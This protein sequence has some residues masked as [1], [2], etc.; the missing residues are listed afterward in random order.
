[1]ITPDVNLLLYAVVSGFPQHRRTH[2]WWEQTVNSPAR[3]G[4]THPALFG[5]LRIAT[6]ARVLQAPLAV[7]DAVEYMHDWLSQ[8]NIDLLIPGRDHVRI[9]PNDAPQDRR[10]R[11]WLPGPTISG[12]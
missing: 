5:F 4:L 6:N 7:K 11:C 8:P 2:A 1:M 12:H 3:V 9:A 10:R